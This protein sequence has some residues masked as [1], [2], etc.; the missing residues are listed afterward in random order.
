[1]LV[2]D[3]VGTLPPNHIGPSADTAVD[4]RTSGVTAPVMG[5]RDAEVGEYPGQQLEGAI[6]HLVVGDH[7]QPIGRVLVRHRSIMA[8]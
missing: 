3:G 1:M 4:D 6:P 5:D 7:E 2:G 8:V